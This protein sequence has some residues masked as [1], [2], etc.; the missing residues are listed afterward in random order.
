MKKKL[1]GHVA[2]DSGQLMVCDPCYIDGHWQTKPFADIRRYI[3]VTNRNIFQYAIDFNNY[4]DPID[5]CGNQTPNQLI[6]SGRWTYLPSEEDK[7]DSFSYN[8]ACKVT[9]REPKGGT[10]IFP[11]GFE[12]AGV[13]FSS[14]YG[15]GT[16]PVYAHY[17]DEGR[18]MKVTINMT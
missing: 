13:A 7:D 16:Y 1:L 2:V 6:E 14:G 15:D 12:G 10:L 3:D 8:G 11:E 4:N 9:S 17:N 18:I 5:E